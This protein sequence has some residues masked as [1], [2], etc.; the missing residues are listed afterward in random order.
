MCESGDD[1]MKRSC[2]FRVRW[3]KESFSIQIS[4]T[5][6]LWEL[7]QELLKRTN[8]LPDRQKI[9]GLTLRPYLLADTVTLQ[10][11][12]NKNEY[13]LI[14]MGTPEEQLQQ[15]YNHAPFPE[16]VDDVEGESHRTEIVH[17]EKCMETLERN[18]KQLQITLMN[19]L[20]PQKR[21]LVLDLDN[22]LMHNSYSTTIQDAIRP[23]VHEMLSTVYPFYDI[24]IW[25]QTSWR[26]LEAKITEMGLLLCPHYAISFV[27][28]RLA[29]A[30][31]TVR[32]K[33]QLK[34][35]SVKPLQVVWRKFPDH[36]SP[37][38]SIHVDDLSR[39]FVL[40]P[41]NGLKVS[42]YTTKDTNDRELFLLTNY[43][44]LIAQREADFSKVNHK[45]WKHYE[46]KHR[47]ELDNIFQT[48]F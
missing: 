11:V 15:I 22:T 1:E 28:D 35:H 48:F 17:F 39:N 20:R 18:I 7:K 3:G 14:L 41:E 44:V 34:K 32:K 12:C 47:R 4:A 37:Q 23:G 19:E 2:V 42:P 6:T 43:L 36:F 16:I 25:S 10:E 26:W 33:R 9:L 27:L 30:S 29:M 40:N 5:A 38:N 21:L 45:K 13:N 46:R 31:V 24:C 8:V